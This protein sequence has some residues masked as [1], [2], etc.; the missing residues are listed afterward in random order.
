[1]RYKSLI[2][3]LIL[4]VGAVSVLGFLTLGLINHT[5]NHTCPISVASGGDCPPSGSITATV[6]HHL[7]GLQSLTQSILST[8]AGFSVLTLLPLVLLLFIFSLS[9]VFS[10]RSGLANIG[11][12]HKI[13]EKPA[14]KS[15]K[16]FLNWLSLLEKRDPALSV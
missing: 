1:M 9:N 6:F 12:N 8:N 2:I 13:E 5:H 4:A 11:I 15:F 7:N 14:F 16:K 3:S 10:D